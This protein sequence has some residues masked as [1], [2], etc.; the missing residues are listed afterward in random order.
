MIWLA[1]TLLLPLAMLFA[2]LSSR[3]RY[4]MSNWLAVA[5]VPG[6][7]AALFAPESSLDLPPVL[8]R[9]RLS[10]DLPSSILLGAAALLWIAAGVYAAAWLRDDPRRGRIAEWWLLTLTGSLGVFMAA[11]LVSFYLLFSMVSLAAYGLII[12]G[13]AADA[14]KVGLIYVALAVFGEA[15]LLMAFVML[16]Q[17]GSGD[18]LL[19]RDAVAA[20]PG[21][22]WR[23]AILA[24]IIGGFGVKLGMVPFHVWMPITYRTAPIPAAAVLSGA[25]VKA[26]VIGL[27]RFLPL[28]LALPDWGEVLTTLGFISAFYGVLIG[29]TQ[30]NPRMVLAFSSVSQMGVVAAVF[31][32]GLG[33]PNADLALIVAFYA[34]HHTLV[35]GGLFLGAGLAPLSGPRRTWLVLV[36]AAIMGLGLAGLPLT[37]GALAKLAIKPVLGDGWAGTLGTLSSLATALLMTHFLFRLAALPAQATPGALPGRLRWSWLLVAAASVVV[38]WA[39]YLTVMGGSVA[40]ALSPATLWASLWPVVLGAALAAAVRHWGSRLPRVPDGDIVM[41]IAARVAR[42][43]VR[44]ADALEWLDGALRRWPIAVLS[45]LAVSVILAGLMLAR[46]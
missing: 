38:P 40:Y 15:L 37:G 30:T 23:N 35:K 1:A 22:P 36:P 4:R 10:L 16:A 7:G 19:I 14:Q 13:R 6:L 42:V 5:A 3:L 8:L 46:V 26:G 9:L 20:L 45:L 27:L 34:A 29:I 33:T 24:L 18:G 12:E 41:L 21:S 28:G 39:L 31:G 11:D 25:A 2:C 43:A 44:T 32:M 17:S